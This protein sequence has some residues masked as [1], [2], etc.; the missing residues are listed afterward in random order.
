MFKYLWI[1]PLVIAYAVAWFHAIRQIIYTVKTYSF[2]H[3]LNNM[4]DF[5]VGWLFIHLLGLFVCSFFAY[6]GML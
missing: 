2:G 3:W 4:E 6:I 5:T 1:V